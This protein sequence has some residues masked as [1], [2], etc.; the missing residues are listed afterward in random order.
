VEPVFQ[1]QRGNEGR[2]DEV[3]DTIREDSEEDSSNTNAIAEGGTV[4]TRT[5][6]PESYFRLEE[7]E[8]LLGAIRWP[9]GVPEVPYERNMTTESIL[10]RGVCTIR[11]TNAIV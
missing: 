9:H 5:Y 6:G 3:Q 10:R 7:A 1:S 8:K 11:F 2:L 4:T